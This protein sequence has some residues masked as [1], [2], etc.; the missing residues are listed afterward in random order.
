MQDATKGWEVIDH[1]VFTDADSVSQLCDGHDKVLK[2]LREE[3]QTHAD[4]LNSML[5]DAERYG[6]S[7]RIQIGDERLEDALSFTSVI[8]NNLLDLLECAPDNET[9]N[10]AK[11]E[12]NVALKGDATHHESA[13]C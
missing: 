2:K 10:S 9:F 11:E 6:G 3:H 7:T 8:Y 4:F 13:A 5:T 12:I 1:D